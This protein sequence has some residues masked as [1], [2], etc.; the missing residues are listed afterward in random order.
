[1]GAKDDNDLAQEGK[2]PAD[3]KEDAKLILTKDGTEPVHLL[4]VKEVLKAGRDAGKRASSARACT[5][6]LAD[7]DEVT[8][9]LRPGF[10][11]LFMA[12]TSWGKSTWLVMV[13]DE[14]LR[15]GKR[16][17]I[18]TAED[19]EEIYGARLL[20]R[21]SG[22]R[23]K[24]LRTGHTDRDENEA[25]EKTIS[26]AEALPVFLDARGKTVEWVARE[27]Q[28]IIIDHRID[29]VFYDYL[30]EMVSEKPAKDMATD[31]D[32]RARLLRHTVKGVGKLTE[33]KHAAA[34][35]IFSQITIQEGKKYID[36][37]SV[38]GSRAVSHGA[39]VIMC[40]STALDD[41]EITRRVEGFE[42]PWKRILKGEKFIKL[43]K[44][45]NAPVPYIEKLDWDDRTASFKAT[46]KEPE[47]DPYAGD[48]DD[49]FGDMM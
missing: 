22:V 23:A 26:A 14:N 39:D 11:W 7:L 3:P 37:N 24:A 27:S 45:K 6:G 10:S 32:N 4:T 1:M 31:L 13:A 18:V 21:R 16:V 44:C 2:L 43:D 30:Q 41:I 34:S 33:G 8:G 49:S 25:I 29:I 36:K 17:L 38:R 47:P 40:G 15:R 19:D 12:D 28:K 35:C 42:Q 5:T 20:A 48:F 46:I 9:G